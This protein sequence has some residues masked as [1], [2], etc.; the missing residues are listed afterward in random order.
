MRVTIINSIEEP[1]AD[2]A[3]RIQ[4]FLT[5]AD[6]SANVIYIEDLVFKNFS[7]PINDIGEVV[8][9]LTNNLN[10]GSIASI[11]GRSRYVINKNFLQKKFSKLDVQF[12]LFDNGFSIPD[13]YF[14]L[15]PQ[16]ISKIKKELNFPLLIK[17][18]RH[19]WGVNKLNNYSDYFLFFTKNTKLDCLFFENFV[20]NAEIIKTYVINNEVFLEDE[21]Y[22]T[23]NI[24]LEKVKKIGKVLSLEVYSVDVLKYEN[25][26]LFIDVNPAP[27]LLGSQEA[28]VDFINYIRNK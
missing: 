23:D 19:V 28:F 10:V 25:N 18:F 21:L 26:F 12:Y 4:N 14:S 5:R 15:K 3:L 16:A 7:D 17:F 8:Y 1:M 27:A 2:T 11:L 13:N 22:S 20:E 6:V 24:L 9:F